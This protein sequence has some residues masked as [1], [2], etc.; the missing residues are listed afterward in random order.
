[1]LSVITII[2]VIYRL[3]NNAG[4]MTGKYYADRM[5]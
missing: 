1:M 4:R 2:V 5:W 3:S